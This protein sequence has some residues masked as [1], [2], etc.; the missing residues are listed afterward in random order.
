MR[1]RL[2]IGLSVFFVLFAVFSLWVSGNIYNSERFKNNVLTSFRKEDV[3]NAI[4]S[5]IVDRILADNPGFSEIAGSPAK[6]AISG[7]LGSSFLE[8]VI[9]KG[10]ERFQNYITTGQEE[11]SIDLNPVNDL[12]SGIARASGNSEQTP[13]IK[14]T[15]LVLVP[16]NAFPKLNTWL[17]V[18]TTL[19]PILGL[20]GLILLTY[21]IYK[22]EV[23]LLTFQTIGIFLLVGTAIN[24]LLIPFVSSLI[25]QNAPSGNAAII[26]SETFNTFAK[27]YLNMLLISLL[28]GI[29]LT[30][31]PFYWSRLYKPKQKEVA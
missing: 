1:S 12:L 9:E 20:T 13:Q 24:I 21:L 19:G 28:I 17:K 5:E 7:V 6:S 3:K 16:A 10:A 8:P 2:L 27:S 15:T 25:R 29:L 23:K 18:I 30:A 4:A 14:N 31:L 11:V 26:A 22:S